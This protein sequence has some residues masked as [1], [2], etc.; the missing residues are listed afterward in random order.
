MKYTQYNLT[1]PK[2]LIVHGVELGTIE[3][4]NY[5]DRSNGLRIFYKGRVVDLPSAVDVSEELDE[6]RIFVIEGANTDK[7]FIFGGENAFW[8][9]IDVTEITRLNLFREYRDQEYW[10]TTIL[11]QPK[12]L[13]IIYEAGVLVINEALKVLTQ[14]PKFFND[15]FV[16]IEEKGIKFL[17]DHEEEWLMPMD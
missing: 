17:R 7:F 13:I 8:V 9:S 12:A 3:R 16:A 4:R 2:A 5:S 14:K 6:P 15:F 10:T 11:E 1:G